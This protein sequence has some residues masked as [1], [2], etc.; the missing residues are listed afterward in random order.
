MIKTDGTP[1][2]AWAPLPPKLKK[3]ETKDWL[4]ISTI[5]DASYGPFTETEARS[6]ATRSPRT[7]RAVTIA[8]LAQNEYDTLRYGLVA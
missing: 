1:T 5:S 6:F 8:S 7:Y 3:P 4:V 2:I